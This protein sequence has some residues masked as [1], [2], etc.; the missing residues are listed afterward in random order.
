MEG[1]GRRGVKKSEGSTTHNLYLLQDHAAQDRVSPTPFLVCG[2]SEYMN[3]IYVSAH[4]CEEEHVIR[5]WAFCPPWKTPEIL[6]EN[7]LL[8]V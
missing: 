2:Q 3:P 1:R 6:T 7:L 5:Q 4:T 8:T